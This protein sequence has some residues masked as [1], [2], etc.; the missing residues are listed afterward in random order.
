MN[1]QTVHIPFDE[2]LLPARKL[3]AGKLNCLYEQ[4]RLRYIKYGQTELIRMI[5]FAVR[6]IDWKTA[7]STI[8]TESIEAN[9]DGFLISCTALHR[10][11]NIFFRTDTIIQVAANSIFSMSRE[12]H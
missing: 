1:V 12:K 8:E 2:K 4:G 11:D 6:D 3:T 10:L 5:Y 7:L 9:G